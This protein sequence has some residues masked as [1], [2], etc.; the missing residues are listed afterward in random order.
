M[1]PN[2]PDVSQLL[3][4]LFPIVGTIFSCTFIIIILLVLVR[5]LYKNDISTLFLD[6]DSLPTKRISTTKFWQNV[7]YAAATVAFL[8]INLATVGNSAAP[9]EIVW[10]IYLGVVASNAVMSKWIGAKYHY[11]ADK[12]KL[13]RQERHYQPMPDLYNRPSSYD[14]RQEYNK[15]NNPY[16][17]NKKPQSEDK[18]ALEG[19][20]TVANP[21]E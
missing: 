7:A 1:F 20:A 5:A 10:I 14:I 12:D 2:I 8:G 18:G 13:D 9:I 16:Q 17:E 21:D 11:Q 19:S 3:P 6:E 4:Y 15:Y